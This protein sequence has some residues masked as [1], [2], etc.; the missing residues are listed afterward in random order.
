MTGR[1]DRPVCLVRRGRCADDFRV[2]AELLLGTGMRVGEACALE[3]RDV[4]WD[5]CTI[6]VARSA[7]LGGVGTT[8]GDRARNTRLPRRRLGSRASASTTCATPTRRS[9]WPLASRCG[10]SRRNWATPTSRSRAAST[11]ISTKQRTATRRVP[12]PGGAPPRRSR[13]GVQRTRVDS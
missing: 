6:T 5:A 3:W 8:K 2:L 7:K 1:S 13:R 11:G 4:N 10:S 9:P 12:P